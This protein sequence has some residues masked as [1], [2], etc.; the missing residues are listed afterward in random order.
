MQ[1]LKH[2]RLLYLVTT[3]TILLLNILSQKDVFV[4]EPL[5]M[6]TP[7]LCFFI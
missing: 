6:L 7:Q 3:L 2:T 4:P 5:Q 1:T